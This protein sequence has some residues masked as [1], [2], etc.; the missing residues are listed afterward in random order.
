[1]V[2]SG[3]KKRILKIAILEYENGASK[4]WLT[5]VVPRL[6][7]IT[8][9]HRV[10]RSSIFVNYLHKNYLENRDLQRRRISGDDFRTVKK[11]KHLP[12]RRFREV[13]DELS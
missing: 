2:C 7:E 1:M 8:L 13:K 6:V 5:S 9:K 4:N 11:R 12:A 3:R 10:T